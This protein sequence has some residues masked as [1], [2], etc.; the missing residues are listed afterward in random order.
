MLRNMLGDNAFF[1]SLNNYL[2]TNKFKSAEAQQLRL[3]FEEVTGKDLNPFFNQWY[4]GNGHPN[5]DINYNYNEDKKQAQVIVKQTQAVNNLF[6]FPVNIDVYNGRNKMRHNVWVKNQVDTFVFVSAAKPDLINFDADKILI[7][8]K[9]ENKTSENYSHQYKYAPNYVDRREALDYFSKNKMKELVQGLNDRY[10]GLREYTLNKL[11][12]NKPLL[13]S[14]VL[15]R[16]EQLA[17]NDPDKKVKAKALEILAKQNDKKYIPLF[18]KSVTDSSYSV[19]GAALEGLSIIDPENAYSLAKKYSA[20]AKGKLGSVISAAIMS[21]GREEDFNS[22][23]NQ[24]KKA[25]P[26]EE[27]IK[28][29]NE[30]ATFLIKVKDAGKVRSGVDEIMKFRNLIP[31]QYR[32]FVDPGFKEGF[33]KISRAKKEEGNSELAEYIN[34]LLK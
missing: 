10:E 5:L 23:F 15:T 34:G 3:A 28:L 27:K 21:G 22:V 12:T 25:P 17:N 14:E 16:V 24:Y 11:L 4:N 6:E 29:S 18:N 31:E 9:T 1:K 30:F 7:A 13:T 20:D 26:S 32:Q 33:S 2:I 19:A 8:Q